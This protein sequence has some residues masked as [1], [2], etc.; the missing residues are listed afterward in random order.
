MDGDIFTGAQ[1]SKTVF[2]QHS[3][4]YKILHLAMHGHLDDENPLYSKLIFSQVQDSADGKNN[5]NAIEIFNLESFR[6]DWSF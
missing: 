5:L 3:G 6:R 1:A 4:R 2:E